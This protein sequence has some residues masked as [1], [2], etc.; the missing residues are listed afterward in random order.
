[1]FLDD[2]LVIREGARTKASLGRP[3]EPVG[4]VIRDGLLVG[5]DREAK[6]LIPQRLRQLIGHLLSSLTVERFPHPFAC[7]VAAVHY[8]RPAPICPLVDT[9][10][11]T[12]SAS[13]PC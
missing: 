3:F 4:K 12:P 8:C 13:F 10:L 9:A 1:M 7:A 11:L 6:L 5:G 2:Y